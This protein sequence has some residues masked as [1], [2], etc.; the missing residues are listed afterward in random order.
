MLPRDGTHRDKNG[1]CR[2]HWGLS[3]RG[4]SIPRPRRY[5][6]RQ[7]P[8]ETNTVTSDK[9]SVNPIKENRGPEW[10]SDG[11]CRLRH[12]VNRRDYHGDGAEHPGHTCGQVCVKE[13]RV[14]N[15]RFETGQLDDQPAGAEHM[16]RYPIGAQLRFQFARAKREYRDF[17]PRAA[18]DRASSAACFGPAALQSANQNGDALQPAPPARCSK[19]PA[20]AP[21]IRSTPN[22]AVRSRA[23]RPRSRLRAGSRASVESA[24]ASAGVSPEAS[25]GR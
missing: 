15:R 23:A 13:V 14:D 9:K 17:H 2:R 7:T 21:I 8:E 3:G 11:G 16:N 4:A 10:R 12:T 22:D 24:S 20:Y 25:A 1:R 6:V 19:K 18:S 5:A